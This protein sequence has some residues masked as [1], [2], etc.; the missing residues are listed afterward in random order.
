[1]NDTTLI[2]G[3]GITGITCARMLLD[4][5]RKVVVWDKGRGIG[6]RLAT[7]RVG[8]EMAFDHGAQY[9]RAA[10][11]AFQTVLE[12]AEAAGAVAPWAGVGD[13][14]PAYVGTPGMNALV[15]HMARGVHVRQEVEVSALSRVEGR[16]A[17][18]HA[19]GSES[20]ERLVLTVPVVQARALLGS[21]PE[22]MEALMP[23]EVA[24]C[25]ALMVGLDAPAQG[26]ADTLLPASGPLAWLARNTAKP[27][28]PAS[29]CWVAHAS[30]DWSAA[31][32][33]HDREDVA[34]TLV[35]AFRQAFDQPVPSIRHLAAHRWRYA[36]TVRPLGKPFLRLPGLHVGGDWCL[37]ARVRHG[38]ES[39]RAMAQ[40][41]LAHT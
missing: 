25:W 13:S 7:R 19:E 6:G 22:A 32:L 36:N 24:P 26:T 33:E 1:M 10:D 40:D 16:W 34:K 3:A 37:G 4:A 39:G 27:G 5:G 9:F 29:E 30:P 8:D 17:A 14:T 2:I 20:F 35:E 21:V 12:D 11:P 28:R 31:N 23:V 15:K 18:E 41:I 38:F